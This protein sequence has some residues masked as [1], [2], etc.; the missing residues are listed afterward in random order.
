MSGVLPTHFDCLQIEEPPLQHNDYLGTEP[1][2]AAYQTKVVETAQ[3]LNQ[4]FVAF[5]DL[6]PFEMR[7]ERIPPS[8]IQQEKLPTVLVAGSREFG[9]DKWNPFLHDGLLSIGPHKTVVFRTQGPFSNNASQVPADGT[10]VR[11]RNCSSDQMSWNDIMDDV[12]IRTF[13]DTRP[14]VSVFC[15]DMWSL[16]N[17]DV[18]W[19]VDG[20]KPGAFWEYWFPLWKRFIYACETY[21]RSVNVDFQAWFKTSYVINIPCPPWITFE[22]NFVLRSTDRELVSPKTFALLASVARKDYFCHKGVLWRAYYFYC[23]CPKLPYENYSVV[24]SDRLTLKYTYNKLFISLILD[25]TSKAI[26]NNSCCK[27]GHLSC[28]Q[29]KNVI[30][31]VCGCGKLEAF[32]S[33]FDPNVTLRTLFYSGQL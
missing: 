33:G 15:L 31:Q 19:T 2:E 21:S 17:G 7:T 18:V 4:K 1:E 25:A 27:I 5:K 16:L 24:Q 30:N 6:P 22:D 12:F 9:E 13:C 26:C 20:A 11:F 32:L 23:V 28:G 8:Q 3:C 14:L 29:L 10:Y